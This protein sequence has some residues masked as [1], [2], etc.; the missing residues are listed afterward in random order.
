[1]D[2]FDSHLGNVM[3]SMGLEYQIPPPL[4]FS[5]HRGMKMTEW[6]DL[7]YVKLIISSAQ[8]LR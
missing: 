6:P 1:M 2:V 7:T 4:N 5:P 8:S 3:S